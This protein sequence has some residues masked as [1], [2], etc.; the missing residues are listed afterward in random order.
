VFGKGFTESPEMGTG[1][2]R[3]GH[4]QGSSS[5]VGVGRESPGTT[6]KNEAGAMVTAPGKE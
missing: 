4:G 6:K 1:S 5:I 3:Q 2:L